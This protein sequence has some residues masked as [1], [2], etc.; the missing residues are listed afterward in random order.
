M[1][2]YLR[3]L[4]NK[5]NFRDQKAGNKF[6]RNFGNKG[7]KGTEEQEPLFLGGTRYYR[8]ELTNAF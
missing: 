4:G 8:R 2:K 7:A 3:E 5:N 1:S 6:E